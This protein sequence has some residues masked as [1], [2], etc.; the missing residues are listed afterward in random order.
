MIAS[1]ITGTAAIS[2]ST[3]PF[4]GTRPYQLFVPSN[5]NPSTPEPLIIGLSGYNQTGSQFEKYLKL[6]P[7]AQTVGFLYLAPDGSKDSH[8]I[9]F[10][11]GTPECCDF[12]SP[13]IDDD[14]Y[15]LKI[16]NEV[17]ARYSVDQ[18]RIYIVGHSNG[19]FLAN[20]IACKNA[21]RIAAIVNFAGGSYTSTSACRPSNPIS[22]LEI[23][24]TN[25]E[26]YLGNHILGR[27]IPG[28]V[29]IF[30][31]W[32]SINHCS[33]SPTTQSQRDSLLSSSKKPDTTVMRFHECP[34]ST[35]IDFW[36]IKGADHAPVLTDNFRRQIVQWLF[37][38]PKV[39]TN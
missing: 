7:L 22:V 5:Y 26:T 12:Q 19:G 27:P 16:I 15:I 13:R 2:A 34:A 21:D 25:D 3:I 28:A 38:H 23:W 9:R 8:G 20:H 39:S 1:V 33:L 14:A 17:S 10:W 11:N 24:G 6:A 29:K 18:N 36:N 32:G 4:S 35:A 30:Y 37:T 31:N